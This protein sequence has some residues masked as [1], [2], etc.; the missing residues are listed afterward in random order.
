VPLAHS[1]S[2][3]AVASRTPHLR[4]PCRAARTRR[5]AQ[6]LAARRCRLR[7]LGDG[8]GCVCHQVSRDCRSVLPPQFLQTGCSHS[9][10]EGDGRRWPT[11][12]QHRAA[13]A[14][15]QGII[16]A[17]FPRTHGSRRRC[18]TGPISATIFTVYPAL[19]LG[20]RR[21]RGY[22]DCCST[23]GSRAPRPRGGASDSNFAYW[24]S[25]SFK[26]TPPKGDLHDEWG[27]RGGRA[28]R[29]G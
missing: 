29:D 21:V 13:R 8:D 6:R 4:G 17:E 25:A 18:V 3:R 16:D 26:K 23:F 2:R 15:V 12:P 20:G 19:G 14:R 7:G 9:R 11:A 10:R 24:H 5:H 1:R 22:G 28:A 27:G